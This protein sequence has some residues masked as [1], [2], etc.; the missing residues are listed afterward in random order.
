LYATALGIDHREALELAGRPVPPRPL[1]RNQ[2]ARLA[3]LAGVLG[4]VA[5]LA[6]AVLLA[7][8]GHGRPPT[9]TAAAVAARTTT[10][11]PPW[12]IRVVVLNGSGDINY[13]R[14]IASRIGALGYEIAHVGRA[15]RF[16]YPQ[17][18]VF[19]P[20]GANAI[21]L[22]LAKQLDVQTQPLPGGNDPRRLVVIV[23]PRTVG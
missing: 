13:T 18:S 4:A 2:W 22:R 11:P 21:A 17:T 12:A 5:A 9:T 19:F 3:V 20:P 16:D 23:G 1:S 7:E 6:V 10:L 14:S 8:R 15:G